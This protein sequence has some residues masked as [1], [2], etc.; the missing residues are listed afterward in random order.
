M[1]IA[2]QSNNFLSLLLT[3]FIVLNSTVSLA[4]EDIPAETEGA[5]EQVNKE[6]LM[7]FPITPN[8]LTSYQGGGK[9]IGYIVVQVQ[10]VVRGQENFDLLEANLPLMQDALTDF[11]NRQDKKTVEDLKQRETL[12]QKSKERLSEVIKEEV[13]KEIVEN[14]LFTQY[15][16][17]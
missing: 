3:L 1:A 7:Y 6:P 2:T 12:R 4:E 14:V 16:F 9:K 8:I 11:F 15:I 13:G 5:E 17:Q 10:V